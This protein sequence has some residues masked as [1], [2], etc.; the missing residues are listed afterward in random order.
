MSD[1]CKDAVAR[2]YEVGA[3]VGTGQ[4]WERDFFSGACVESGN[5]VDFYAAT[6]V[7]PSTFVSAT[8]TLLPV[9]DGLSAT[10]LDAEDGS[11]DIDSQP[12]DTASG[13]RCRPQTFGDL[14]CA[15]MTSATIYPDGYFSDPG[16]TRPAA[17]MRPATC[18]APPP[19]AMQVGPEFICHGQQTRFFHVGDPVPAS[20]VHFGASCGP[21]DPDAAAK[22]AFFEV[23]DEIDPSTFV[24]MTV[25]KVGAKGRLALQYHATRKGITVGEPFSFFD[26]KEDLPCTPTPFMDGSLRCVPID[27]AEIEQFR[28]FEDAACSIEIVA[29]M[30]DPMCPVGLPRY[31]V[32]MGAPPDCGERPVGTIFGLGAPY[33]GKKFYYRDPFD[34]TCIAGVDPAVPVFELGEALDPSVFALVLPKTE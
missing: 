12:T 13:L 27:I 21:L 24:E 32:A 6:E 5:A 16:C 11:R 4:R 22:Q 28:M 25:T 29:A 18:P 33:S 2:V 14:R 1:D 23:G 34:K 9:D 3:K 17:T 20:Q 8:A 30:S 31:A 19:I 26:S 10:V 15:P 7:P